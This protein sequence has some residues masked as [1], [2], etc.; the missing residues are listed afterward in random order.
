[1]TVF[2]GLNASNANCENKYG[3]NY[4]DA[5]WREK[6]SASL[7]ESYAGKSEEEPPPN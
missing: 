6:S 2:F 4:N 3:I 7:H 5:V 1:M